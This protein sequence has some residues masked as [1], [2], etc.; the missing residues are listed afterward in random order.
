M[1]F[2]LMVEDG[3][4]LLLDEVG[5]RGPDLL[6]LVGRLLAVERLED[7]L[8]QLVGLGRR[9][10]ELRQARALADVPAELLQE[11]LVR[12][13]G[14]GPRPAGVGGGV[15]RAVDRGVL[16]EGGGGGDKGEEEGLRGG[17]IFMR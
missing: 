17:V 7:A 13:G 5:H 6:D 2:S 14:A 8:G 11:L 15:W 1:F 16:R 12:V 3:R 9:E 4:L 10:L